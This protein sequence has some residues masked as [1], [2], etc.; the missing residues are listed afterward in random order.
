LGAKQRAI[1]HPYFNPRASP[2]GASCA[3]NCRKKRQR[4]FH[5]TILRRSKSPQV[6]YRRRV[7][8][9]SL[10]RADNCHLGGCVPEL[11]IRNLVR[12]DLSALLGLYR[13]LHEVDEPL[14]PVAEVAALRAR[15]LAD[16]SQIYLGGFSAGV[17]VS[18]CSAAVIPNLTRGGRPYAVIEN[19]V[20]D[21]A[22][23]PDLPMRLPGR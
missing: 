12:D 9:C 6:R 20:T 3:E 14:P 15:I 11:T 16:D 5:V 21:H 7:L 19:V 8:S 10:T 1:D 18:V 17:L 22:R 2:R 23:S 4:R 13:Q